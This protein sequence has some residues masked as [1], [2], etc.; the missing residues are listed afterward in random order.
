MGI[1]L[2]QF[3][4]PQSGDGNIALSAGWMLI[5]QDWQLRR[6]S[7]MSVN[8][9]PPST[10]HVDRYLMLWHM[11]LTSSRHVPVQC[12]KL[13]HSRMYILLNFEAIKI[14]SIRSIPIT[15]RSIFSRGIR[16]RLKFVHDLFLIQSWWSL[17]EPHHIIQETWRRGQLELEWIGETMSEFLPLKSWRRGSHSQSRCHAG[18]VGAG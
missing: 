11:L 15:K 4:L 14:S 18:W 9:V 10:N 12:P 5:G 8:S 2:H 6:L 16:K 7:C 17:S 1:V 13:G 3:G